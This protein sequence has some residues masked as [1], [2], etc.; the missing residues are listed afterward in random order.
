MKKNLAKHLES[1]LK[2]QLNYYKEIETL[3]E[4]KKDLII[5]GDAEKLAT[6]DRSIESLTCQVLALEQKRFKMLDGKYARDAKLADIINHLGS[7]NKTILHD[8][9]I[10]LKKVLT[11]IQKL[12][13]MNVYLIEN[14]IR[15]IEHSV[16]TIANFLIPESAAYT[17]QGKTVT[18][19]PYTYDFNS[20]STIEQEA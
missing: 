14:S 20:S 13:K 15:W 3:S 1:N 17:F 7:D 9:R 16:T 19:S 5:K 8:I 6:L 12:N 11:N 10:N 18:Q 2:Q 4:N